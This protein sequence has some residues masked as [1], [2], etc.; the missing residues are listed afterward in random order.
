MAMMTRVNLPITILVYPDL[1]D[2]LSRSGW[3]VTMTRDLTCCHIAFSILLMFAGC[4]GGGS[5]SASSPTPAPGGSFAG[6]GSAPTMNHARTAATATLLPGGK[7]LIAGGFAPTSQ[8]PLGTS[9]N[10]VELYDPVSDTFAPPASTPTM[11]TS[12]AN[13]AAV[14]LPSDN[15]LIAGG[16]S[17]NNVT[18]LGSV[19][20]YTSA[21]NSF[22][23]AASLPTMNTARTRAAAVLLPN[24]K[25]LIAGGFGPTPLFPS[26]TQLDSIELYDPVTNNFAPAASLP[27]MSDGRDGP[28]ATL[29]PNGKVLIAGGDDG[30]VVLNVVSPT[31]TVD[32]Y[33]PAT[34]SFAASTPLMNEARELATATLLANDKV[35]IAGGQGPL[36]LNDV[37][38][39]DPASN[40][41]APAASTPV[42]NKA[43]SG[44]TATLLNN[45]NVLIAGGSGP[46]E[47][48]VD[49]YDPATNSFFP[50]ALTPSMNNARNE[51]TATLLVN[52]KVLIAG[53]SS[54]IGIMNTTDLYTQ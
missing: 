49:I 36:T 34:N 44:A 50:T 9:L 45:G 12:R 30:K 14:V 32:L 33:D 2:D 11:N 17:A 8:F 22:A 1:I 46:I 35:L 24:G 39:Y 37:D 21:S 38:L 51:A 18:P 26:G 48:I 3:A 15:V 25:V 47:A 7:V 52:G 5:T 40:T 10:I 20:L 16:T 4:G 23:P 43:R 53:G 42:M 28:T 19:E 27:T 31:N 54:V 6:V 29:L 13:A 41:F